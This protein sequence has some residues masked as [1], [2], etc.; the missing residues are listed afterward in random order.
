MNVFITGAGLI[1]SHV[2]AE[3]VRRGHRVML[4]EISPRED[5]VRAVAGDSVSIVRGDIRD[6]P[7]LLDAMRSH[8]A[9]L[10]FHSAALIGAVAQERPFNGL[11]IALGGTIAVAEAAR[12]N[13]VKR[14]V[15]ASTTGVYDYSRNPTGFI[16]EDFPMGADIFYSATKVSNEVILRSY[17]KHYGFEYAATRFAHVYGL[18]QYVGGSKGGE[19]VHT[20]VADTL[21]GGTVSIGRRLADQQEYVYVKD[22]AQGVSHA[23]ERPLQSN[24]YNIGTGVVEGPED[25]AAALGSLNPQ[26]KFEFQAPGSNDP[27][28]VRETPFDL[29]RSR[30]ELGY[31][32]QY[33]LAAGIADFAKEIQRIS[34]S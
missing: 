30:R 20:A 19:A 1:G 6:T 32:P 8:E 28:P 31:E 9:D 5:F 21:A 23:L 34:G 33:T 24:A 13:G 22:V 4:Y 2:A 29:T 16:D 14:I 7:A 17:A 18:G 10:V 26:A 15:F 11:N 27:P 12:L 25:L 3:M